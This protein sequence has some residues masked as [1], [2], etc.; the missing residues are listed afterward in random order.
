MK[1]LKIAIL[2]QG[3]SGRNIH[4][5]FIIKN[6]DK[7]K[8]VAVVDLL[9]ERRER[10][11]R[12]YGCDT[13]SDYRDLFKRKDIDL[14]INSTISHQHA[15]ITLEFL[16]LGF[17][18][19]CEKPLASKVEEVDGLIQASKL[20]NTLFAIF[21]ECRYALH[22]KQAWR[23]INS[24]VLGEV[25]QVSISES[26]FSRRWDWQTLQEYNGGNLLNKGPHLI[27]QALQFFG[28]DL[29]P[30]VT[31]VLGRVNTFGDAD[32]YTK[33]ILTGK[34]R[35]TIDIDMSNC[36]AYPSFSINIQGT[37][38][39]LVGSTTHLEWKY[40]I[41]MESPKQK[42]IRT[43]LSNDEGIPCY[44]SEQ[45]KWYEG[46]WDFPKNGDTF[47]T[48]TAEY[49]EMIYRTLTEG[50]PLEI[51]HDEVRQQVA[52]IQE[53][54]RQNPLSKLDSEG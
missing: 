5:Q 33:I 26:N 17:N 42:L 48:M 3:R 14:V 20:S 47:E 27:D 18:V 10:A 19:L 30:E 24:G 39:G 41:P 25:V 53:C 34:G 43:S 35:P 45:L 40:F 52:V 6:A 36:C 22:I 2:G 32:D 1:Q 38:G 54:L 50:V 9:E 12:E 21:Q 29:M 37:R 8:V 49:Y 15:P 4:G 16:K 44:C 51:T 7:F 23:V 11:E 13:Y 31:S 46:K 28:T